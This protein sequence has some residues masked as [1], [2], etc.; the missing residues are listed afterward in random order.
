MAKNATPAAALTRA[1][2]VA[3]RALKLR[4]FRFG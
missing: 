2:S 1:T 4:F 3:G